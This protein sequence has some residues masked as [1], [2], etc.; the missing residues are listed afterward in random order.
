MIV[1]EY[2]DRPMQMA[3]ACSPCGVSVLVVALLAEPLLRVL[4]SS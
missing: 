2:Q 4:L 3:K 1:Q